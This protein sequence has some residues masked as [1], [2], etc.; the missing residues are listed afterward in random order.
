MSI[1]IRCLVKDL[2]SRAQMLFQMEK[3]LEQQSVPQRDIK[4]EPD[5]G[6]RAHADF[7]KFTPK[8]WSAP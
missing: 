5:S 7:I 2:D 8:Q 6:D 3:G 4:S 1:S